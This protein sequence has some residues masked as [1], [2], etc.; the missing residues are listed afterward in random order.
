[1]LPA[2]LTS[3]D[4]AQRVL[5]K[6]W[7]QLHLLGVPAFLLAALHTV[8]IG[9]HYLG[10]LQGTGGNQLRAVAIG[11]IVLAVLCVRSRWVWSLF[12]LGKFYA[13]PNPK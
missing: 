6:R 13:S 12:S 4:R 11:V 9:S 5:G 2:V 3:F 8:L 7:R 1:M 10:Q